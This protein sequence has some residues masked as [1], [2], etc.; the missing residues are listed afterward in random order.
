MDR[1]QLCQTI[2][3]IVDEAWCSQES[4]VFLSGIPLELIRKLPGLDYKSIIGTQSLKAF[5][6]ETGGEFGYEL[7]EHPTQRAKIGAI[8]HGVQFSFPATGSSGDAAP[9]R[10]SSH[11]DGIAFMK[12]LGKLSE[13]DLEKVSIPVS[14]LVKLFR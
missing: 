2:K 3:E 9:S 7:V 12:L 10:L 13:A 6:A 8:P 14:V 11:G 1:N 4:P 5:M